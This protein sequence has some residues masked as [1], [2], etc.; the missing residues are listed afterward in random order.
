MRLISL[1]LLFLSFSAHSQTVHITGTIQAEGLPD[2]MAKALVFSEDSTLLKGSYIES[3]QLDMYVSAKSKDN[4]F[5]TLKAPEF[6]DTSIA[7]NVQDTIVDLG[8]I[9]MVKDVALDEVNVVY[10]K[11]V[12]ERTMNGLKVNVKGTTLEG[13]NTLFDVLKASPRLTSPDDESIQIIG[14]GSPL[15]RI[16]R[17]PIISNDELRAIPANQVDRIEIITN[18]SARYKAQGVGSGVIEVYTNNFSLEG[19]RVSIRANGGLSTQKMPAGGGNLGLSFKKKKFSLNGYVGANYNSYFNEG[20]TIG[21]GLLGSNFTN[22]YYGDREH[23]WQYYNVKMAYDFAK[24]KK[25]TFGVNGHGS[26]G[27]NGNTSESNYFSYDTLTNTK[28]NENET[29]YKWLGN[30]SFVNYTWQPDTL[31]SSLEI[32]LNY[33]RK[34]SS[35]EGYYY[36]TFLDPIVQDEVYYGVHSKS[37]DQPNIGEMRIDYEHYFDTTG[38][39][40]VSGVSYSKLYNG[41]RYE[42]FIDEGVWVVDDAFTND[43]RYQEDIGA[44]YTEL[45]KEWK[46]KYGGGFRIGLRGEFTRLDGFS[47]VLNAQFIDSSYFTPFINGGVMI[48]PMEEL[49]I[50]AYYN[51]GIDRPQFSNFD[52]FIRINDSLNISYGNPYLRPSIEHTVG[53]EFDILYSYNISFSYSRYLDPESQL[54]FTDPV[55]FITENT[56]WNAKHEDGIS[57]S[58]SLPIQLKWLKGWNSFWMDYSKYTFTSEFEREPFYNLTYGLYSYLSFILPKDFTVMNRI[59]VSRWGSETF[60]QNANF[61][62]G[63][64]LTKKFP[65]IDLDVFGEVA[66]ILPRIRE[67]NNI[68]SNF[69]STTI[70]QNEFTTFKIGLNYKFGRL[71]SST[72]IK[73]SKSGQSDR[74]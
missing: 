18:P 71:K 72:N 45:T 8:T 43:Y 30:S 67:F 1:F 62:W 54:S 26:L 50:T 4:L 35:N 12:F 17:Q 16:D 41:K 7:L 10:E 36:S 49:S 73:D 69:E 52:P 31:G 46:W 3:N 6:M 70:T 59:N 57:A 58:L 37:K 61:R 25:L 27:N 33:S 65:D 20:N 64:R 13:L 15:I 5:V 23:V 28:L 66:N 44:I 21:S 22:T 74:I 19:Y 24:D 40:L 38:W 60:V 42:R 14:R 63:I 55:T 48:E 29:S 9:V 53:L 47:E 34:N 68:Q 56:P 51:S 32:N 11:P 2:N 39:S